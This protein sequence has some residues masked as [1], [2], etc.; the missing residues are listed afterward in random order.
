MHIGQFKSCLLS[1]VYDNVRCKQW[2]HHESCNIINAEDVLSMHG[3]EHMYVFPGT[4]LS[5]LLH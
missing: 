1:A 2:I 4:F 5:I 3:R